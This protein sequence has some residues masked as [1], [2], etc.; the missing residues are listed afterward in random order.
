MTRV[1]NKEVVLNRVSATTDSASSSGN[2]SIEVKG[3][4][5]GFT[6][7][8]GQVAAV[9]DVN[10]VVGENEFIC[11]L[12]PSGCGKT[13]TLRCLRVSSVPDSGMIKIGDR[14]VYDSASR[15]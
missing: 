14:V 4:V 1:R 15:R 8:H 9:N 13:T 2:L 12:G 3:L 6:T 10:F 11:L 5:K 7:A